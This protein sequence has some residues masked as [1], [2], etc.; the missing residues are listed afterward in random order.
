MEKICLNWRA[1]CRA[2]V[3]A[4]C[5]ICLMCSFT[6][7]AWAAGTT[8]L[9]GAEVSA[10]RGEDVTVTFTLSNNPGIWALKGLVVYNQKVF[11]LKSISVGDIFDESELTGDE[12]LSKNPFAFLAIGNAIENKTKD[13]VVVKLVLTVNSKAELGTHLVEL[14]VEQAINVDGQDVAIET[15]AAEITLVECLHRQT[16]RKNVKAATEEEEGYTGDLHCKKCGKMLEKGKTV[17]KVV[18]T[19]QHANTNQT[20]IL[21]ATCTTDGMASVSCKDCGKVLPEEVIPATGHT[22]APAINWKPATTTEEGYTGDIYCAVCQELIEAGTAIPKIP[23]YVFNMTVPT[24]DT[25]TRDSQTGLSFV[26][27]ADLATFVRVEVDGKVLDVANYVLASDSTKVTL[28]PDYLETLADGKHTV[29]IVSDAGT[30]SAQFYVEVAQQEPTAPENP[31]PDDGGKT[32]LV[33]VA[34]ISVIVA[35]GCIAYI[36][37]TEIKRHRREEPEY[38][39]EQ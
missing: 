4:V 11:T 24:G 38:D 14:M 15:T 33:I 23:I 31:K 6:L 10:E 36:V 9:K 37:F 5:I 3:C 25:Y 28:K 26:S 12:S 7:E 27:E 1:G 19:C 16:R 32:G 8:G 30:A 22:A 35:A 21:E 13:G 34:I 17:P 39:E 18:N 20:V 2:L 29:T